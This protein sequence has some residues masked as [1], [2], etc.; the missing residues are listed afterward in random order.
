MNGR[1]TPSP[2]MTRR[3]HDMRETVDLAEALA[4]TA[5]D[6]TADHEDG[7]ETA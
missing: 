3:R 5:A 4:G 7:R 6:C 2:R 1:R